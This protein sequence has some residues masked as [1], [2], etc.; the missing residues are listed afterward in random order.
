MTQ[1]NCGRAEGCQIFQI[2]EI[3]GPT[4]KAGIVQQLG[5]VAVL[6]PARVAEGLAGNDR[7]EGS[8]A[9]NRLAALRT[10]LSA[11]YDEIEVARVAELS[12][13]P[14]GA[15]SLHRLIMDLHKALNRLSAAC[16]EEDVA[17]THTHGLLP[18]DRPII[19][20]FMGGV[21]RTRDLTFDHQGL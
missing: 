17:G 10:R 15:D 18:E 9:A 19:E 11:E 20:A 6:L 1:R 8:A 13:L 21:H 7:A 16:A 4:M 2:N 5:E 14:E 12:A 3:D